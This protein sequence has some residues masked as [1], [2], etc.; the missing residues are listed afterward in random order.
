MDAGTMSK[1]WKD[2]RHMGIE[3]AGLPSYSLTEAQAV[4]AGYVLARRR[5]NWQPPRGAA[6]GPAP[7]NTQV[8]RW[9]YA[10]YDLVPGG[11]TA[12]P[13]PIDILV[14]AGLN[15]RIESRQFADIWAVLPQAFEALAQV[16]KDVT[17]WSL[18]RDDVIN[19]PPESPSWYLHR[20]W[21]LLD[22]LDG[23]RVARTHKVLHHKRPRL[24]PLVDGRTV[25]PLESAA[26]ANGYGDNYW[27]EIHRE[28]SLYE[29]EFDHLESWFEALPGSGQPLSRL[30]L[31]DI[32]VWCRVTRGEDTEARRVGEEL[33]SR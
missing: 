28:L 25:K 10:T 11:L 27:A 2:E 20:A 9:A 32:L 13:A 16:P 14:A 18:A 3:L 19:P 7:S 21:W 6:F 23:V 4:I 26:K 31:H 8:P 5:L 17:F 1:A 15:G 24:A 22:G 30:R 29:D 12:Q 33:L